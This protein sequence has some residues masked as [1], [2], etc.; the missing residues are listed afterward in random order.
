MRIIVV[1]AGLSGLMAAHELVRHGH[2]VVVF[3]KGRGIGGR[4]ATRRIEGAALDH[5]AQFFT[6]RSDEFAAHVQAWLDAG[7]V[8]EWC[9][10]FAEVDGHPRYVGTKGMSGIAKHLGQGL[11]V[12]LNTLVFSLTRTDT[13]FSV[14]LDDGVVHECDGLILTAPIPQ[15]FSLMFSAE[16][17]MPTELRSIDYDRTLGLL[18]VLDSA[19]HNVP[20]PGGLQ[21]PDDVF[22]FIGDNQAK[23]ISETPS[24]TFHANPEWS[25]AHF[26]R[27]LDDI[28][29]LLTEAA[30]P[31]LGEAKIVSSQPKKWRFATPK[32][33][34]PEHFWAT[35]DNR[36]VLAGDAFA[37]PK[38]EGAALSGLA[39]ARHLTAHL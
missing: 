33:T 39:A 19:H 17:E 36:L 5:G 9:K 26:E 22:S 34:W 15:S 23:G 28:H 2:D 1:G 31:W 37:G 20:T 8:R 30:T 24:L 6:V 11:D 25:L 10:G 16:M 12:R 7:V 27:E 13:H 32:S 4:L 29:A 14:T 35:P 3:D 21:F 38:M 18:A